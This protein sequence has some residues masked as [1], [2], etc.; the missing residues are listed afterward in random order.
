M[1][2]MDSLT[3]PRFASGF[4]A[5]PLQQI[6]SQCEKQFGHHNR[7]GIILLNWFIFPFPHFQLGYCTS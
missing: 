7:N 6:T 3:T 5:L 2:G 4:A 1:A